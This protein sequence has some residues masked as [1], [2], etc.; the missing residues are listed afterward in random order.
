MTVDVCGERLLANS[1]EVGWL[2]DGSR[3]RGLVEGEAHGEVLP[4]VLNGGE[5][6]ARRCSAAQN[7]H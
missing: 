5:R 3:L 7:L 1:L 2:D 4:G 6:L